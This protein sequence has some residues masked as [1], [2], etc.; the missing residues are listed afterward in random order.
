MN[1]TS[2]GG[3][4]RIANGR[5]RPRETPPRFHGEPPTSAPWF[6]WTIM[7]KQIKNDMEN[8]VETGG[9]VLG[10]GGFRLRMCRTCS[11]G[12]GHSV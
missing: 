11:H 5:R 8:E 3:T 10:F 2:T 1:Q 9:M 7:E 4:P 12:S 6:Q